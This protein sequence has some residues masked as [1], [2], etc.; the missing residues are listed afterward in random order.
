[1]AYQP[2]PVDRAGDA[3]RYVSSIALAAQ[4]IA[5]GSSPAEQREIDNIV[6]NLMAAA[7]WLANLGREAMDEVETLFAARR[8]ALH[9]PTTSPAAPSCSAS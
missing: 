8:E 5:S 3:L 9:V 2:T 1:M 4:F 6:Y 7:E